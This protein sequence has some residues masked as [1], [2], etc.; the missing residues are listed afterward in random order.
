MALTVAEVETAITAIE[1]GGQSFTINGLSYTAA[2]LTSL[3][4]LR[5]QIKSETARTAGTRPV[6]RRFN[7]SGMGYGG[8]TDAI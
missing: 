3:I 2:N 4:A 5:D 8:T 6:F 1:S 7:L